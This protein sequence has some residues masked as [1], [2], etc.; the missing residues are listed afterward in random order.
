[1]QIVLTYIVN[2]LGGSCTFEDIHSFTKLPRKSL[3]KFLWYCQRRKLL[4]R[5][6]GVY[7]ITKHGIQT[8]RRLPVIEIRNKIYITAAEDKIYMVTL[9]RKMRLREF[10][11][12]FI[13]ELIKRKCISRDEVKSS[14]NRRQLLGAIRLLRLLKMVRV[15]QNGICFEPNRSLLRKLNVTL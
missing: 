7:H 5:D 6:I 1:M 15:K 13:A 14:P 8:I 9:G 12:E 11:A 4:K 10:T 3:K 2:K